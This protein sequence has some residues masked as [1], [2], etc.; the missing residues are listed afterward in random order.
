MTVETSSEQVA[1]RLEQLAEIFRQG[2]ASDL[3]VQTLEKLFGYERENSRSQLEKL[4]R[5]LLAFEQ[6]HGMSS[7]DFLK[8]Y[9]EGKT[10]DRMDFVEWASLVQMKNRLE[11][12]LSILEPVRRH[13]PE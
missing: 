10:D 7:G 5:D 11:K 9:Q 13:E 3:M 12:R 8:K 4:Q 2:H 6:E 1:L